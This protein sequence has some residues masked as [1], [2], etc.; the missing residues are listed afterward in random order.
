MAS[1][2]Q[3]SPQTAVVTGAAFTGLDGSTYITI[4]LDRSGLEVFARACYTVAHATSGSPVGYYAVGDTVS[5]QVLP[6]GSAVGAIVHGVL[7]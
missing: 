3:V 4:K 1:S 5:V 2:R 7:M 6:N